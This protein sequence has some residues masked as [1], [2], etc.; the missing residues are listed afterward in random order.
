[1]SYHYLLN[2]KKNGAMRIVLLIVL[3]V[4]L[5]MSFMPMSAFAAGAGVTYNSY[6]IESVNTSSPIPAESGQEQVLTFTYG[7]SISISD[8]AAAAKAFTITIG[9]SDVSSRIY[10]VSGSGTN[11]LTVLIGPYSGA[12]MSG[13]ITID[14][15]DLGLNNN[16]SVGGVGVDDIHISSVVPIGIEYTK[17]NEAA[18]PASITLTSYAQVRG[19]FH[20]GLYAQT[21]STG[22]LVPIWDD[23]SSTGTILVDTYTAHAHDFP[24]MD[25]STLAKTIVDAVT[26]NPAF[27]QTIYTITASGAT[28][29]LTSKNAETLYIYLFDDNLI[30]AVNANAPFQVDYTYLSDP[31][32]H[33]ILPNAPA[34]F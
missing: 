19:M 6:S 4:L 24:T 34:S 1:M 28:V 26:I 8:T 5:A 22:P 20:I 30:Q 9:G 17:T 31:A 7:G 18:N 14:T 15:S 27:D 21:T 2:N 32:I 3:S 11:T 25:P 12:N 33:G 16:V 29:T 10:T 13:L 23:T